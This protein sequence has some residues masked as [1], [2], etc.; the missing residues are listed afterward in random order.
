MSLEDVDWMWLPKPLLLRVLSRLSVLDLLH[1]RLVCSRW[2][3]L[4]DVLPVWQQAAMNMAWPREVVSN[5]QAIDQFVFCLHAR[6]LFLTVGRA[7]VALLLPGELRAAFS[8][9]SL[10]RRAKQDS[11]MLDIVELLPAACNVSDDIRYTLRYAVHLA[12]WSS[13]PLCL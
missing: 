12:R 8:T 4:S 11:A 6:N 13:I 10:T 9:R 5:M 3:A 7:E 2:K 1:V